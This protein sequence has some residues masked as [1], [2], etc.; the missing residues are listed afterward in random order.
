MSWE[1]HIRDVEKSAYHAC[2]QHRKDLG[3]PSVDDI[4]SI[5]CSEAKCLKGCPHGE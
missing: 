3:L 5:E 1:K 2:I 4:L